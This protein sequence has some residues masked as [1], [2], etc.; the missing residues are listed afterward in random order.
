TC[1]DSLGGRFRRGKRGVVRRN[2]CQWN[3]HQAE[4]KA[5]AELL[6]CSLRCARR[7]ASGRPNVHLLIIKRERWTDQQLGEPVR[8]APKAEIVISRL[9]ARTNDVRAAV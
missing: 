8:D 3:L 9:H 6:L 1:G 4:P 2:D 5:V 7:S